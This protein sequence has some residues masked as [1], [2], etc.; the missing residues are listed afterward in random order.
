MKV[1][2]KEWYN[3]I[4]KT[5][6]DLIRAEQA[7]CRL[8]QSEGVPKEP[9]T[10]LHLHDAE[11]DTCSWD[12]EDFIMTFNVESSASTVVGIRFLK[13]KM[14]TN[15]DVKAGDYWLYQEVYGQAGD[16]ELHVLFC[17]RE[18]HP[19]EMIFTFESAQFQYD[20]AKK[21]RSY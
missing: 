8:K 20:A 11:L 12:G 5:T 10:D 14:Q 15:D 3:R 7:Y 19:K 6:E 21:K 13:A 16:Y 4:D 9:E 18:N 2:T 17:N 1:Y